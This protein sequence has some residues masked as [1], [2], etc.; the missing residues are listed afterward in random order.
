MF[1]ED[2]LMRII[3]QATAAFARILGFKNSGQYQEAAKEI[4]QTLGIL[5]GID[6]EIIRLMDDNSLYLLLKKDEILDLN[7]LELIAD[8][9]KEE[10]DIQK[11]QN[12]KSEGIICYIRSL[13][14]Y[15]MITLETEI[16]RPGELTQKIDDLMQKIG[17]H[18]LEEMT[19]W[20]LFFYYEKVSEFTKAE[21]MLN[22]LAGQND[23]AANVVDEMKSFYKRL[24]EKSS[25]D[26]SSGGTNRTQIQN[27]LRK[28]E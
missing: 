14:F 4:D 25:K 28:L 9:F 2:Y 6:V 13:N 18:D 19:L 7:K 8:L 20:N 12:H 11:L 17:P 23:H 1:S 27:K 22:K 26:L 10:G 21:N 15:L 3:R 5:F 16:S 24:L